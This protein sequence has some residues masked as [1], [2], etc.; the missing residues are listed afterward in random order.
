MIVRA[1][2]LL[3]AIGV[4]AACNRPRALGACRAPS[5]CAVDDYCDFT[6]GLC[7]KGR[8]PGTCRP[9][10]RDCSAASSLVCGCDGRTYDSECA[11]HAAG[12]DLAVAGGCK[13]RRDWIACGAHFCDAHVSYCEIVLSDVLEPPTDFTCKPLPT[14]CLP[15]EG[16]APSCSCFPPGTRCLSFCG[17]MDTGGGVPGFHLTCRS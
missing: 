2:L 9:R 3:G 16:V 17:P 11:A 7:G 4:V 8:R 1:A 14:A 15:R 10:A 13:G 12:I 5:D 6:P